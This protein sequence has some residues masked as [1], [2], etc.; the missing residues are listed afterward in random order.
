[1]MLYGELENVWDKVLDRNHRSLSREDYQQILFVLQAAIAAKG[2]GKGNMNPSAWPMTQNT[3]ARTITPISSTADNAEVA[4]REEL[5]PYLAPG[6]GYDD[7]KSKGKGQK[8]KTRRLDTVIEPPVF[9]RDRQRRSEAWNRRR[10]GNPEPS[11]ADAEAWRQG[12]ETSGRANPAWEVSNR[13]YMEWR[14]GNEA[15]SIDHHEDISSASSMPPLLTNQPADQP[16]EN[17]SNIEPGV[18]PVLFANIDF[19]I[20]EMPDGSEIVHT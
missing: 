13:D 8:S 12:T 15:E 5:H 9:E 2:I 10:R 17:D 18:P 3:W 7:G 11:N 20:E 6:K 1:M 16:D 14:T 19:G 4:N